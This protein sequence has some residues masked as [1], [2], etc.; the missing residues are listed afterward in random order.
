M[1]EETKD[2]I[3]MIIITF[4]VGIIIFLILHKINIK[5]DK[6]CAKVYYEGTI[7]FWTRNVN[8]SILK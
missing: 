1:K 3:I 8:C 2:M 6:E 4:L 7:K 5:I